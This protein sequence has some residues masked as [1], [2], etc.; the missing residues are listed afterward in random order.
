M[1]N[2]PK[3]VPTP[4]SKD[5][6]LQKR[7]DEWREL[8]K[9]NEKLASYIST[10]PELWK[11]SAIRAFLGRLSPR[12]AIKAKCEECCNYEDV[13]ER[14]KEC[15]CPCPLLKYRPYK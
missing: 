10:V 9:E 3:Y 2:K 4:I 13:K 8:E 14:I 12:A 5:Q 1:R 6:I 7:L 15:K 11:M